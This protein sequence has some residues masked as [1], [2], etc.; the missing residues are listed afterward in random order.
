MGDGD[1]RNQQQDERNTM[2]PFRH[3]PVRLILLRLRPAAISKPVHL[4]THFQV[5]PKLQL[6]SVV[7]FENTET[8]RIHRVIERAGSERMVS[9]E[10]MVRRIF[11]QGARRDADAGAAAAAGH[12]PKAMPYAQR[13]VPAVLRSSG[14]AAQPEPPAAAPAEA[15]RG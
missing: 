5:A 4:H 12:A 1:F 11:E 8:L 10:E 9:R 6:T 14:R 3:R 13:P 7:S 2:K 15:A